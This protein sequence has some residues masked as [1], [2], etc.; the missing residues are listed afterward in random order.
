MLLSLL[1]LVV[2]ALSLPYSQREANYR[3]LP[4]DVGA[5]G[6]KMKLVFANAVWRH[7]DRSPEQPLPGEGTDKFGEKDWT[8]GGGGYGE[9]SPAGMNQQ[10]IV[11]GKI[12]D[13]YMN[14][15]NLLT[16]R[17]RSAEIYVRSTDYNRTLISAYS[18]LAGMYAGT[19]KTDGDLPS[20]VNGW[21][22]AW[23]PIP[24]HTVVNKHDYAGN[25][26]ADCKRKSQVK[27]LI[28]NSD[29]FIKYNN[30]PQV[31]ATLDYLT[32][33][34]S[35]K[36]QGTVSIQNAYWF[37]DTMVCE[38]L[39]SEDLGGT[40]TEAKNWYPW[41]W[42][43]GSIPD[44]LNNIVGKALDF[45]DGLANP[46]GV[47][48]IDVSIEMPRMRAGETIGTIYDMIQGALYCYR[49][50]DNSSCR[51]FYKKRRY[52]ALSAHDKT[53]AALL[54]LLGVKK[55]V[56]PLGYPDYAAA[57]LIELYVNEETTEEY[58]K[59]LYLSGPDDNFKSVTNYVRGCPLT[60]EFCPLSV[61]KDIVD[62]YVPKPDMDTYCNTDV[63]PL[64]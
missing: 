35:Q 52:F 7:G 39:H 58:F 27:Q 60:E 54:T 28:L 51:K 42:N 30:D 29:E 32:E 44:M 19:E 16:P 11:G 55:Y 3:A 49:D 18:N 37:Q 33:Q 22:T 25:P 15:F 45:Q 64:Q 53:V 4:D 38:D 2:P 61:L 47:Q 12:G 46:N 62:V 31:K 23:V 8:F 40:N 14:Q 9:L 59:V 56:I 6:S 1:F 57:T 5:P 41:F 17:Y 21:P 20:D 10:Y 24:V 36:S 63:L 34:S 50:A 48:G 26:D 43:A 13:R